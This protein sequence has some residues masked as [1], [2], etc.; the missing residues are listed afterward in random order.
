MMRRQHFTTAFKIRFWSVYL[1]FLCTRQLY[2]LTGRLIGNAMLLNRDSLTCTACGNEVSLVGRWECAWCGRVFDG[3]AFGRCP[4]RKCGAVPPFIE[5]QS[6][7]FA[8]DNPT[9]F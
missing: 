2:R 5:C 9:L 8:I 1:P 3:F 7:G 6:C 4:T